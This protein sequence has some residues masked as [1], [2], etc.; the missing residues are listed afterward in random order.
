MSEFG[1]KLVS[2]NVRF[3]AAHGGE[4]DIQ[5]VCSYTAIYEY[6]AQCPASEARDTWRPAPTRASEARG[7]EQGYGLAPP[8]LRARARLACQCDA[9][10]TEQQNLVSRDSR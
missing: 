5:R 6:T 8:A 10:H 4:A 1:T 3:Y 2:R 7:H 9:H